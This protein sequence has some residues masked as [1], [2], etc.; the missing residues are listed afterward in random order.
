MMA[1]RSLGFAALLCLISLLFSTWGSLLKVWDVPSGCSHPV[2]FLHSRKEESEGENAAHS[3]PTQLL[4]GY[5]RHHAAHVPLTRDVQYGS[6]WSYVALQIQ[7]WINWNWKVSFLV[8]PAIFS[9]ASS[10]WW[11][12]AIPLHC[13]KT[14]QEYSKLHQAVTEVATPTCKGDLET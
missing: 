14:F 6:H 2:C 11:H 1:L 10:H 4:L 9:V 7:A 5:S 3:Y 12:V 13:T 8:A